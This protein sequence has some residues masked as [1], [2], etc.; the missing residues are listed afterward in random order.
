MRLV[1]Y[2]VIQELVHLRLQGHGPEYWQTLGRI[3]PDYEGRRE[4]LR[5]REVGLAW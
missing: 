3:M 2:A 5:Q 4:D 1:D